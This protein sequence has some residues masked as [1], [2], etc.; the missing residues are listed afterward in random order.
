MVGLFASVMFAACGWYFSA[1][2]NAKLPVQLPVPARWTLH[3]PTPVV[4]TQ[5]NIDNEVVNQP[6]A[7]HQ[8]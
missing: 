5:P 7:M 6:D 1:A 4:E 8:L 3:T 2:I